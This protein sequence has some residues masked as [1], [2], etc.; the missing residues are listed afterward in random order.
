MLPSLR[1]DPAKKRLKFRMRD[2]YAQDQMSNNQNGDYI[3]G[4]FFK[5]YSNFLHKILRVC[6]RV[7]IINI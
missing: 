3:K 2:H 6:M 7:S 5:C 4:Y 1:N